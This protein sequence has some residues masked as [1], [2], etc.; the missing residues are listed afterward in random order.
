[1][2]AFE[3]ALKNIA[4]DK[5]AIGELRSAY[6]SS[7]AQRRNIRNIILAGMRERIGDSNFA[8]S[9]IGSHDPTAGFGEFERRFAEFIF[10]KLQIIDLPMLKQKSPQG[11]WERC[12]T[13]YNKL[14]KKDP[15]AKIH[16]VLDIGQLQE[17]IKRRNNASILMPLLK[18][19]AFISDALVEGALDAIRE[20]KSDQSH[21]RITRHMSLVRGYI[22][23]FRRI[24]ASQ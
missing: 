3:E 15:S 11:V 8:Q 2:L 10:D 17:I 1:M 12:E 19:S 23:E 21:G 18:D 4:P 7:Y 9:M 24:M 20:A 5:Q 16:E 22:T 6:F 14:L 13:K